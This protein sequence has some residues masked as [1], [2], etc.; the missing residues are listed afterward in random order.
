MKG[1][2]TAFGHRVRTSS[3]RRYVIWITARDGSPPVIF[4]RTDNIRTA[5]AWTKYH[6]NRVAVDTL[7]GNHVQ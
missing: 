5:L 6:D 4:R 3:T 1:T 2:F 7:T